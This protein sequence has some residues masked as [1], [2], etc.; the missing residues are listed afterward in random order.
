MSPMAHLHGQHIIYRDLK[1]ENV[2][3]SA[4][5]DKY[6]CLDTDWLRRVINKQEASLVDDRPLEVLINDMM[7]VAQRVG[8]GAIAR[9]L[10]PPLP[11]D[12]LISLAPGGDFHNIPQ[13]VLVHVDGVHEPALPQGVLLPGMYVFT[14]NGAG[15]RVHG[16]TLLFNMG[17]QLPDARGSQLLVQWHLPPEAQEAAFKKGTKRLVSDLFGPW[18]AVET[19]QLDRLRDVV[20]P[21]AILDPQDIL[22]TATELNS[23][24]TIPYQVLDTLRLQHGLDM[25]ALGVSSTSRGNAYRQCCLLRRNV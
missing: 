3:Q 20:L 14:G 16:T 8:A 13:D 25:T 19:W 18:T 7:Q 21:P 24:G 5:N 10:P 1:L 11:D 6:P 22:E 12:I 2:L 23:D 17:R 4:P 15:T 9:E